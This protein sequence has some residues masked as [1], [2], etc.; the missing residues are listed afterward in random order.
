MIWLRL[1]QISQKNGI[2]IKMENSTQLILLLEV[3]KRHGGN[4]L[5]VGTSGWQRFQA[6]IK[7]LDVL[8]VHDGNNSNLHVCNIDKCRL[9]NV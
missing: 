9:S 4:V 1:D 7:V 8:N 3:V 6:G 5:F 2:L